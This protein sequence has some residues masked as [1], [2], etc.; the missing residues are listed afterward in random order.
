M[1]LGLDAASLKLIMK[2]GSLPDACRA[3]DRTPAGNLEDTLPEALEDALEDALDPGFH[4]V[5]THWRTRWIRGS[6]AS[7]RSGSRVS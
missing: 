6:T 1:L 4:G 3:P 2:I 5:T 7:E